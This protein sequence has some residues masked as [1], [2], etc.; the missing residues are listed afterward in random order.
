VNNSNHLT[1]RVIILFLL[2]VFI[3]GTV[4]ALTMNSVTPGWSNITGSSGVPSCLTSQTVGAE[5]Q[6]RF[7]DDDFNPGCPAD[8]NVQSGFGFEGSGGLTFNSGEPFVLGEL[9]HY[10]NP[11]F[12]SS[13]LQSADLDLNVDFSDPVYTDAF[14]TTITLDETANNLS[15]CPFGDS[16][17]CADRITVERQ[18][19]L[20][21]V[22]A[23]EYQFEILG[24]IPGVSGS[25]VYDQAQISTSFISDEDASNSACLF[26]SVTA[27]EDAELVITKD[28]SVTQAQAGD[29]IDYQIDYNC[30]ST[31]A[32]CNGGLL[33]DFLPPEVI[34]VG[35]TGSTHT[36]QTS[37]VYSAAN[38]S[39]TFT[40][41]DPLPA[42][43]TGFIRVR[44][45][46][47][48]DG[49][50][51]DGQLIENTA[52][53]TLT[54]GATSTAI[55]TLPAVAFSNWN[56]VKTALGNVYLDT[57]APVTDTTYTVGICSAGSSVNLLGAQ[58]VDTLPDGSVFVS[59]SGTYTYDPGPPQTI[60]WDMGDLSASSGCTNRQVTV[61]FPEPPFTEAQ[62]IT[63]TV[64][65]S[66]TPVVVQTWTDTSSVTN[67]L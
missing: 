31:T 64:D 14:T 4:R 25:C 47:R 65:A 24:L 33:T 26:G 39:V 11:V 21:T 60:T 5:T 3:A 44:V 6:V 46:M 2:S 45:R 57:D 52:I 13:L 7:G 15:T 35:S 54:N 16:Q 51:A 9:T 41:V 38:H 61:R 17:P 40:F 55:H 42:G 12:A 37:G 8:F 30:F 23:T 28:A 34:Y 29:F 22:G 53:T 18:S 56:V 20:F 19:F 58:M 66:G 63:N 10:N 43:S 1:K 32:S 59:A 50:V 27:V 62:N 67:P 36:T 48:D 49:T